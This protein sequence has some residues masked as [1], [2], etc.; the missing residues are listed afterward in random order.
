MVD[1]QK[2]KGQITKMSFDFLLDI[3]TRIKYK[4]G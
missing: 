2:V 3:A 1:G 4:T